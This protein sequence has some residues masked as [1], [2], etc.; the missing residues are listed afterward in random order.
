N[1]C[2][3]L[4]EVLSPAAPARFAAQLLI[5]SFLNSLFQAVADNSLLDANV[6][7]K[8]AV[9]VLIMEVIIP[10]LLDIKFFGAGKESFNDLIYKNIQAQIIHDNPGGIVKLIK[11]AFKFFY[12]DLNPAL[13]RR[14][15]LVLGSALTT[16]ERDRL[17]DALTQ[18]I[19]QFSDNA[20]SSNS[21]Q[22]GTVSEHEQASSL[23]AGSV[24]SVVEMSP[25]DT[26]T[27]VSL[28]LPTITIRF[29]DTIQAANVQAQLIGYNGT[30]IPM[31]YGVI[32]ETLFFNLVG[33]LQANTSYT[34]SLQAG[35]VQGT[36]TGA[37]NQAL[38][39]SFVAD[40]SSLASGSSA[41]V[42]NTG[43]VGLR[44]RSSPSTSAGIVT[45]L[46][47]GTRVTV[48][49]NSVQASGYTWYPVQTQSGQTGWSAT[50][51]W[52]TAV[53]Q[54]GFR[55]GGDVNVGNTSGF[56]LRLRVD[57]GESSPIITTL[58][59]GTT[60]KLTGDPVYA[61]G[62]SWFPVQTADGVDGSSAVARWLIPYS[63]SAASQLVVRTMAA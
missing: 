62:Y 55:Q 5:L 8:V 61:D 13:G 38:E 20:S 2:I 1:T 3:I 42:A 7:G 29:D 46:A 50:G 19:K 12:G 10:T 47:E 16:F 27:E 57:P 9:R 31:N 44:L 36:T 39:W 21:P 63:Q 59:D 40:D 32:G 54:Y 26:A 43:G 37:L 41:L 6:D 51:N 35:S 25:T 52:L 48:T 58:S 14:I 18:R 30:I 22:P 56:G 28:S 11:Q 24:L 45:T 4:L 23:T 53:D 60:V 17:K 49:G 34:M 33:S 15:N